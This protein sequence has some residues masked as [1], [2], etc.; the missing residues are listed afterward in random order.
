MGEL[1]QGRLGPQG[2]VALVT[3]P[4][5]VLAVTARREPGAFAL[6]LEGEVALDADRAA[7]LLRALELPVAGRFTLRGDLPPGGGAGA[8]TAAL[9]ALARAA[10]AE[11]ARIATA[12]RVVEGATDPLMFAEPGR[13]LW[14]SRQAR[15]LA[16]LPPLPRLEM[17][18]G[19][20]GPARRTDPEDQDFPDIADLAA[21]WPD[22]CRSAEGVAALASTSARRTLGSRGPTGDP[23]ERLAERLGAAGFAIGHTGPARALLFLPGK[24]PEEAE[25]ALRAAGFRGILRYGIGDGHA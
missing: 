14:A 12:C 16:H 2:P 21:A 19:F 22:A 15:V 6:H 1:I 25:A 20:H 13:L 11:E 24:V 7:A 10:G 5:P 4:C 18:A 3:L 17:L 8:S 23:T 9:V